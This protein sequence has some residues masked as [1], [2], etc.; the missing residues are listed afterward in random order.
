LLPESLFIALNPSTENTG[1]AVIK[2]PHIPA[3]WIK[4][5]YQFASEVFRIYQ[6]WPPQYM[7]FMP[8]TTMPV[9]IGPAAIILR[10]ARHLRID[11]NGNGDISQPSIQEDLIMLIIG[12]AS[13]YW[14]LGL[15]LR[16]RLLT[17][18]MLRAVLIHIEFVQSFHER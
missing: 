2:V 5:S 11:R 1:G 6:S 18:W 13:R 17:N 16:G 7:S 14:N 3:T 10:Y 9:I 12:H 4:D 15:H 8:P